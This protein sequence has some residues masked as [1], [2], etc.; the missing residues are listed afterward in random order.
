M[1]SIVWLIFFLCIMLF[2][3]ARIQANVTRVTKHGLPFHLK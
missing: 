1:R 2:S 3:A